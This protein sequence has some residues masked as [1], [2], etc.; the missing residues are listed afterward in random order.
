[1]D[2]SCSKQSGETPWRTLALITASPPL[3]SGEQQTPID[4][5]VMRFPFF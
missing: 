1:M 5:N 2:V 4:S 3:P